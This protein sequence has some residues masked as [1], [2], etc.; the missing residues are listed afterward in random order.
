MQHHAHV[1]RTAPP[2]LRAHHMAVPPPHTQTPSQMPPMNLAHVPAAPPQTV[3]IQ[4]QLPQQ[5]SQTKQQ[6]HLNNGP[7]AGG[8][9]GAAG[10]PAL[11]TAPSHI[12]YVTI[13]IFN[14]FSAGLQLTSSFSPILYFLYVATQLQNKKK[15]NE[16]MSRQ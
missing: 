5:H 2:H 7:V 14:I 11:T 10:S 8:V 13:C 3:A 4:Q 16:S 12:R 6:Q 15:Q 9:G 1:A